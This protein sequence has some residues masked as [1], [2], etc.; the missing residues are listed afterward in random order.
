MNEASVGE[1]FINWAKGQESIIALVQIGSRVR[2]SGAP[3]NADKFSDWDFQVVTSAPEVFAER[4]RFEAIG[5]GAPLVF[6]PRGGRLGSAR[7][8]T[9][10]LPEGELDVVVIPAAQLHAVAERVKAGAIER[11]PLMLRALA[12]LAAVLAGGYRILKGAEQVEALYRFVVEKLPPPRLSDEEV[13]ALGEGFVCDYVSTLQKIARGELIAAQ[14]WLHHQLIETNFR[15]L[16]ELRLREGKPSFPD[17][18]RLECLA[19]PEETS[20]VSANAGLDAVELKAAARKAA[21]TCRT[22]I[23][24]LVGQ[25]WRWPELPSRLR[26]E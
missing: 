3:G 19:S 6:A 7:K 13:V 26:A 14:R 23:H 1:R 16:H 5:I 18:R 21:D 15:L 24:S 4:A 12:D 20:A 2:E 9:T 25:R 17:A 22:F 10:L 11:E 8:L